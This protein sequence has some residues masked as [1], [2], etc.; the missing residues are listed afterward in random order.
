MAALYLLRFIAMPYSSVRLGTF[1]LVAALSL[2]PLILRAQ[3]QQPTDEE[4]KM[5]SDPKA[6]GAAAVFLDIEEV[7]SDPLHNQ[8]TYARIKVLTE[9]GKEL[10]TVEASLP[11]GDLQ[12]RRHQGTHH[13]S[14]RDCDSARLS[15]PK[16]SWSPRAARSRSEKK[17]FT[18]PSVEVGSILEYSYDLSYND[19]TYS[20]PTWEI[21]RPYF[22][23]KAHYQ[24][25][26]QKAFM[27]SGTPNTETGILLA[28][29][30]GRIAAQP[31]LVESP[32]SRRRRSRPASTAVTAW[33]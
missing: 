26:P 31:D 7:A 29:S 11:E 33:T 20:S 19:N 3:F 1:V 23:H 8:S 2:S 14:R 6:P 22:V 18:L 9:K 10:A 17:V 32:A 28:D 13:P 21:Q 12:D 16:I 25:T 30:R 15:N 24:F 4:L 5:T 27:P